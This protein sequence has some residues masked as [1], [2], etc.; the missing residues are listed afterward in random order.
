[1]GVSSDT[2]DVLQ[3]AKKLDVYTII[4]DYRPVE[5]CKEK[6]MADEYWMIDLKDLD[7][8]EEKSRAEEVEAVYAGNN[9][10]CLDQ[11]RKLCARLG[12][13]FYASEEGWLCSRDKRCIFMMKKN[14]S[15]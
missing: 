3:Y 7:A 13:P 10:F 5:I 8:L 2:I 4:T 9:E 15:C 1:M 11:T 12:L 14:E 6:E